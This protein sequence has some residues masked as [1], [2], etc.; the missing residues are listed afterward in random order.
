MVLNWY[1]AG[2]GSRMTFLIAVD[3][4]GT[5]CRA[6][7]ADSGGT[8]LG[9][10]LAGS[11]NIATDLAAARD[12]I[13]EAARLAAAEAGLPESQIRESA[14]VL[15]LA[16]ANIGDNPGRVAAVLPFRTSHVETDARIALQGALGERDGAVAVVGTGSVFIARAG[17]RIRTVGGWG[18]VVG[19][20]CSGARL[21][22]TLLEETLLAHDGLREASS[23][24]R[25]V[26]AGYGNS[27]SSLVEYAHMAKPRDFAALAPLLFEYAERGDAL[28]RGIVE[29]ATR[30]LEMALQT[31]IGAG[32]V[33]F[34]LLGGLASS[35]AKRLSPT[36][37]S[38]ER[39]PDGNALSGALSMAVA[40]FGR[41]GRQ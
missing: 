14:A 33:P 1:H 12:N 4:G 10:G 23:L 3:G 6:V 38:R 40:M 24:A 30:Q 11:A 34:C 15:G 19:D 9:E 20:F 28:A 31:L 25:E 21:G 26:L 35:Y 36:F 29:D 32:D 13:V 41:A 39:A 18:P 5:S 27:P 16:G 2:K 37:R 8:L 7:I 22:R 17:G